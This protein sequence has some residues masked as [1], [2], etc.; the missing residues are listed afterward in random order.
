MTIGVTDPTLGS[1][2]PGRF[3][4]TTNMGEAVPDVMSPMCWSI[5]GKP[6]E[7]GWL[8]SMSALGVVRSRD[9]QV[10]PDV[11]DWALS[12]FYGRL[13]LN[14]DAI[15]ATVV[16]LP[17]VNPDDFE[18][19][20][21]GSVRS[22]APPVMGDR[23]RVPLILAKAPVTLLRESGRIHDRYAETKTWW[24][25]QVLGEAGRGRPVE[26]L[27]EAR[28]RFTD[29]FKHHCVWRFIFSGAQS[30]ITDAAAEAG[31]PLLATRLMSGVG[32]VFETRMADDLWRLAHSEL[33]ESDFL[34][35]WGYHG[36]NEGNT[37]ATVW[38]EDPG[39]VR[40]LARSFASRKDAERPGDREVRSRALGSEAEARLLAATPALRRPAMRWL[41]RRVRNVVRTL[42]VGKASY[43]M[44]IDGVRRATR[45]FGAEQVAKGTLLDADD[46]FYLSVEECQAL[47]SGRLPDVH[48]LVARRRAVRQEHR[49]FQLPVFFRGMP[50]PEKP[51]EAGA[52]DGAVELRGA[53]SGGGRVEGRARV[54]LDVTDD[55]DLDDGDVL[56]CRFTDPSWAPLMSLA[57]ALVIDVGG[58]A[59]HGAVVAREL[60]IPYV[61]GTGRGTSLLRDGDRILVDGENNVVRLLI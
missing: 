51:D 33:S 3:W 1:S 47:D 40:A 58:S 4:T 54:L 17:G 7:L 31:D 26:R 34:R 8:Y 38:R 35:L 50:Q 36:P 49:Q 27:V 5:W 32:E 6:A 14:V 56:V 13:A 52:R 37:D 24:E 61:I 60:G 29:T 41:M 9:V 25:A 2:E 43:L 15:R 10:S 22:D 48:E 46:A 39:P 45:D 53:A 21:W 23:K 44:C 20:L 30:A 57:D 12:V 59:S 55:I 18:R 42:Q 16:T 28:E 19:D 11:N